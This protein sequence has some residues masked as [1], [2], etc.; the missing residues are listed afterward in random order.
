MIHMCGIVGYVGTKKALPIIVK[1][2]EAL[3]YRGYDSAGIAYVENNHIQIIKKEGRIANLQ[4]HLPDSPS[5]IGIGHTRWATHGEA[6]YQNAHP[7]QVGKFTIVHNGIIEN[8]QELKKVLEQE[9][10]VMKSDT[11]TEVACALLDYLY[12]EE[13]DIQKTIDKAT[14]LLKGSYAFGILC[15]D[16]P[17][18]IYAIRCSS[19]LIVATK[20][21]EQFIAS[22][23]PA[24]LNDTNEYFLLDDFDLAVLRKDHVSFYHY[25]KEIQKE[26]IIFEGTVESSQKE[27]F[28]HFMLKE[29][30]EQ[31][32]IVQ[33]TIRF[34][35]DGTKESLD[36]SLPNLEP[37]Q[38]IHIVACGSAYHAGLVARTLIEEIVGIPVTCE[39]AS[40]Y[41]YKKV[42]YDSHTLVIVIS[43][44]GETADTLASLRKANADGIDTLAIVN[45]VGSS[46]A[47]EAKQVLYTKAG[48]EI[49]VATT[50]AYTAQLAILS[51]LTLKLACIH[52]TL[53]EDEWLEI[54]EQL[55]TLPKEM[56]N[57]IL[58]KQYEEIAKQIYQQE[59]IFYLGRRLDYS[60]SLEGA[61][62]LKE[63]SYINSVSY[64]AGELKHGTISLIEDKTPVIGILT[65]ANVMEKTMSNLEET[66]AR[67]AN[68][69]AITTEPINTMKT[70]L[71]PKKHLLWQ[72]LLTI[73]P[74]QLLAYEIAKLRGS[75]IDKPRNLAKSVTVE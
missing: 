1:G 8:Y 36:N 75:D 12:R 35:F 4:E 16:D 55:R 18:S 29:I 19:P 5:T 54:K 65:D 30:Y 2:L 3:E 7:H 38:S 67:G 14:K 46:I 45:V 41:R 43:Q 61:L 21:Q 53:Q 17:E 48:C 6:S 69:F 60:I 37:Y 13:R 24:I 26:K 25:G 63:I 31:P 70:I 39:I 64:P 66:S 71:I 34:Y 74:L 52:H 62:K 56:E 23:V 15:E 47:R 72:S 27:G 9:N 32:Q 40:E 28:P 58:S 11:D 20:E 49:A 42:F 59:D 68:V 57:L 44:S 51:L 10:Y 22:D 73:I 33:N 50:K